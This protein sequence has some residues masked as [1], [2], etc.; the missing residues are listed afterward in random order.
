MMS[1]A[2]FSLLA[3]VVFA[4]L[5]ATASGAHAQAWVDEKG[6]ASVDVTYQF[7][8]AQIVVVGPDEPVQDFDRAP[9]RAHTFSLS[10]E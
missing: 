7:G 8:R 3:A 2:R 1:S 6:S 4:T 10:A 5:A 9:T